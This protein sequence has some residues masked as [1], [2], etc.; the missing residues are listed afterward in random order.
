MSG[1]NL[2]HNAK[3]KENLVNTLEATFELEHVETL[4]EY[5]SK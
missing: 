4:S 2:G 5:L 3:F 1:Q